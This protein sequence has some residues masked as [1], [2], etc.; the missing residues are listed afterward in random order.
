MRYLTRPGPGRQG[1]HL[2]AKLI[3]WGLVAGCSS[4]DDPPEGGQCLPFA[5]AQKKCDEAFTACLGTR[6][7][8]IRGGTAGH[9][10]CH[11]CRDLC[12]QNGG[13]WPDQAMGRRCR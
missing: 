6:I 7:Q 4:L 10:Q 3:T 9:S 12:M 2:L 5:E 8:S 1:P 13:S 11:T